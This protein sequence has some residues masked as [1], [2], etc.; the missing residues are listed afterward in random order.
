MARQITTILV[1]CV[2][3]VFEISAF[4]QPVS[5][6]VADLNGD[7]SLDCGDIDLLSAAI[8]SGTYDATFDLNSNGSLGLDDIET[9]RV[10]V[11]HDR[12][13]GGEILHDAGDVN[14]DGIINHI[15]CKI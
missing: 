13:F 11:S 14:F 7:Q 3:L 4:A 2:I 1:A 10:V 15:T 8:R 9:F 12:G 5:F 6:E